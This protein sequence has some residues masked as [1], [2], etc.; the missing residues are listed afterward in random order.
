VVKLGGLPVCI[1]VTAVASSR[2]VALDVIGVLDG[3]IVGE[4]TTVAIGARA[5]V[6]PS[7]V[8]SGTIHTE[9]RA[10]KLELGHAG[11]VEL[12]S[13]P[14]DGNVASGTVL[15]KTSLDVIG[16]PRSGKIR[17]MAAEAVLGRSGELTSL[18]A[19]AAFNPCVGAFQREA[20]KSGVVKL[21]CP[22]T[23]NPVTLRAG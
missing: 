4:M 1:A 21:G 14:C 20:G 9:M 3:L 17:G 7:C 11:V 12:R 19:G 13:F 6:H 22:P 23:V 10:G 15:G 16:V 8:T 5:G 2:E 18:V